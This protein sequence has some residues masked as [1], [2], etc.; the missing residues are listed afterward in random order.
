MLLISFVKK[1]VYKFVVVVMDDI[2]HRINQLHSIVA[3]IVMGA[4]LFSLDIK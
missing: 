3:M 1:V 4:L 2:I